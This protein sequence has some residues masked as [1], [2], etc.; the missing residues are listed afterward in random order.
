VRSTEPKKASEET[1]EL[2]RML[3]QGREATRVEGGTEDSKRSPPAVPR[4]RRSTSVSKERAEPGKRR[5]R[6]ETIS[7]A[8]RGYNKWGESPRNERGRGC[9][10]SQRV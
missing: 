10:K 5:E 1:T 2:K 3:T 9:R 7:R 8:R 4:T 6:R